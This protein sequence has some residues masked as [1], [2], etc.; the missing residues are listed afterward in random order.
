MAWIAAG[1]LRGV[2][3]ATGNDC[4]ATGAARE[5]RRPPWVVLGVKVVEAR[6]VRTA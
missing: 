6:G 5:R 1:L 2:A 3:L 4:R